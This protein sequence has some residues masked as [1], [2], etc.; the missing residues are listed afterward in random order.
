MYSIEPINLHG[1][2]RIWV[3]K[4]AMCIL[5][6]GNCILFSGERFHSLVKNSRQNIRRLHDANRSFYFISKPTHTAF[7]LNMKNKMIYVWFAGDRISAI[8]INF[9]HMVYE[10]AKAILSCASP[11]E[12]EI[13]VED[14]ALSS[15][16]SPKNGTSKHPA[17]FYRSQSFSTAQQVNTSNVFKNIEESNKN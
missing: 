14:N 12:V 6:I 7:N 10:D 13:E 15:T 16:S 11:Y 17:S 1:Y 9:S 8:R 2:V 5:T 4:L 3:K